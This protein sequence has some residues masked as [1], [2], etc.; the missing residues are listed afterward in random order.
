MVIRHLVKMCTR[1][2]NWRK[3]FF[4]STT[5][6]EKGGGGD[7]AKGKTELLFS[8]SALW[9]TVCGVKDL[10]SCLKFFSMSAIFTVQEYICIARRLLH[11]SFRCNRLNHCVP[12]SLM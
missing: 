5:L 11:F 8:S 6:Q 3:G 7:K 1:Q 9:G 12:E 4:M 2:N 10:C